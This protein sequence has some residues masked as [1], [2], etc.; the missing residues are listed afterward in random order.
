MNGSRAIA[1]ADA[2]V[3]IWHVKRRVLEISVNTLAPPLFVRTEICFVVIDK[4]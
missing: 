3:C 2:V 4:I 1:V